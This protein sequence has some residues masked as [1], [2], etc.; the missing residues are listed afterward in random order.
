MDRK[1]KLVH[2]YH[3]T[4]AAAHDSEAVDHLLVQD[5][6]GAPV[7]SIGFYR[8]AMRIRMEDP[9]YNMR[10]LTLLLCLHP[11]LSYAAGGS[12]PTKPTS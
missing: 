1:Y 3:V 4:D 7:R 2:R 9:T 12:E 10:R 8:T 5:D 11:C 6:I